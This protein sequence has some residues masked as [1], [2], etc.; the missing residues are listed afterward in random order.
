MPK[1]FA[2][3]DTTVEV[4]TPE[5]IAFHYR[6]AGPFRRWP[7][8]LL[9]LGIRVF[10][11]IAFFMI[12]MFA[13]GMTGVG[14]GP[15][16]AG[17]LIAWFILEWFYGGLFETFWSGQT[18][19]KWIMGIRVLSVNGEPINGMQAVMRN[20]LRLVDMAPLLSLEMLGI[21]APM[22]SLPT[23]LVALVTMAISRRFQR[24]GDL[25]CGTVVVIEERHWLTGVVKLE[26]QRAMRLAEFLPTDFV[27]GRSLAQAL[28]AYVERRRYFT[29]ERRKE[30]AKHLAEPLL[31]QFGL[32]ADT[33]HDLLL[34]ALYYKAFISDRAEEDSG[35]TPF[36]QPLTAAVNEFQ[37]PP[38]PLPQE[39]MAGTVFTAESR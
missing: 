38:L 36:A 24:I 4:V 34:C 32:P 33:S 8:F 11:F 21:P 19:G 39:R 9:D 13:S 5:N 28:S 37:A 26:D 17:L 25:V 20:V 27:V 18:P 15:A 10:G 30:V 35:E 1:A 3:L 6:V 29:P 2:Q 22:Y 7:A 23:F 31:D 14:I 16:F 12:V